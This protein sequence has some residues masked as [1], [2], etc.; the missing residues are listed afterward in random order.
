MVAKPT[1][2]FCQIC[3]ECF[4][5]YLKV[6][7]RSRSTFLTLFTSGAS[8]KARSP[9]ASTHSRKFYR[10]KERNPRNWP[11]FAIYRRKLMSKKRLPSLPHRWKT[12]S[13]N[14]KAVKK[15]CTSFFH[16]ECCDRGRCSPWAL[17]AAPGARNRNST[18][19]SNRCRGD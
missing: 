16:A 9:S 7:Q 14:L 11:G 17:P 5:D 2:H 8:R 12:P 1:N 19:K 3:R 10:S 6:I 15:G 4:D 18:K 13:S